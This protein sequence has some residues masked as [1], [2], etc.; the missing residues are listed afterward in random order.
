M[1]AAAFAGVNATEPAPAPIA[2]VQQPTSEQLLRSALKENRIVVLEAV[3]SNG[4]AL[5]YASDILKRNKEIVIEAIKSNFK[6]YR[7]ISDE[8]KNDPEILELYN[9][10]SSKN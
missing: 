10:L 2:I 3:R 6:A 9:R 7:F 5:Q 1:Y 8:L 4:E